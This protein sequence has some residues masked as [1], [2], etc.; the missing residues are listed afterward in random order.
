MVLWCLRSI[1]DFPFLSSSFLM[2]LCFV[3]MW[4]VV[5]GDEGNDDDGVWEQESSCQSTLTPF[6]TTDI[7]TSKVSRD[8]RAKR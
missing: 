8:S 6:C 4:L 7:Y 1:F 3:L 2:F 5:V